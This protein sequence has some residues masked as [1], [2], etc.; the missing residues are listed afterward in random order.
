MGKTNNT[1]PLRVSKDFYDL[2]LQVNTEDIKR[3]KKK[4]S[5]GKSLEDRASGFLLKEVGQINNGTNE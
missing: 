2:V 5:M 4:M 1:K 3:G